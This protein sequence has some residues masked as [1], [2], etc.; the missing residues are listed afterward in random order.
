M[1]N[2]TNHL[3]IA[4][5]AIAMSAC[6]E[7]KYKGFKKTESG[8]YYRLITQ[9]QES[10]PVVDSSF[11]KVR[12]SY[13]LPDKN[14]SLIFST[15][16]LQS[17][18]MLLKLTESEYSGDIMEGFR[19]MKLGDSAQFIT[20]IDSFFIVTAKGAVPE[21]LPKGQNIKLAVRILEVLT[22]AQQ[23]EI[24]RKQVEEQIR[25]TQ[26]N[27]E[28]EPSMILDYINRKNIK[29]KPT[30]SGMYYI[31]MVKGNGPKPKKNQLVTVHYM[32][33]FLNGKKFDS[34]YDRDR[35]F[36]FRLGAG[37]VIGGWDEG[38]S[39][40]NVGTQAMFILPSQLAYGTTGSPPTIPPYTPLVFEVQLLKAEDVK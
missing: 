22:P 14:D 35:P 24:K 17:K 40:M 30:S 1:K 3:L 23:Q 12:M 18:D 2:K 38:V 20:S 34:S 15:N 10:Q 19:M 4:L 32:G 37:E 28:R 26:E 9:M 16:E 6:T 25:L 7:S 33:Y 31:E 39:Y 13:Y 29:E 11:I 21:G 5:I 27:M 8:L 36:Q